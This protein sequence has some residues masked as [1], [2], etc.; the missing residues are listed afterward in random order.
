MYWWYWQAYRTWVPYGT[1]V[2]ARLEAV[3]HRWEPEEVDV[4]G[5]R[6]V[7]LPG[8]SDERA[9]QFVRADPSR[10]REVARL[11]LPATCREPKRAERLLR[12]IDYETLVWMDRTSGH[13]PRLTP[14]EREAGALD[15]GYALDSLRRTRE[16]RLSGPEWIVSEETG[17]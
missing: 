3:F 14:G 7:A 1:A 11:Q 6:S 4:G 8:G 2:V 12:P 17:S 10:H 5:G 16:E 13:A 9:Q 15:R